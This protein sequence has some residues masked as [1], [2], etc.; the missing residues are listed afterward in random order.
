MATG[1]VAVPTTAATFSPFS[2]SSRFDTVGRS[3]DTLLCGGR[4]SDQAGPRAGCRVDGPC[5]R[6]GHPM[7]ELPSGAVTFLFSDIEGSTRLVKALRERYTRVLAEHRQLIRAAIA[8]HGGHEVD[9]QGDAFF[10]VF[11]E[12]KQAVL[13]ALEVQRSLTAHDW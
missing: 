6:A 7:T 11:D 9:T 4:A 8:G 13:C 12:A 2:S 1:I 10:A 5:P 3:E